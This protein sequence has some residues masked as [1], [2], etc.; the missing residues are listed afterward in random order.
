MAR[1]LLI[2]VL[3][4]L[5][6]APA[7][8]A[9][10]CSPP[11]LGHPCAIEGVGLQGGLEPE[12]SLGIGNPVH[13]AT[14]NKH[15]QET[16]LPSSPNAPLLQLVRH[17]N[18]LDTRHGAFGRGWSTSY[19][20]RLYRV[21]GRIQIVQADG[22][23]ISF[24]VNDQQ[25]L[26]NRHGLLQRDGAQWIWLW[27]DGR[28]LRF[29]QHGRLTRIS[30]PDRRPPGQDRS[31]LSID[32]IRHDQ[33]GPLHGTIE[34]IA[35]TGPAADRLELRFQYRIHGKRAYVSAVD[36]PAGRFLYR[37]EASAHAG[38]TKHEDDDTHAHNPSG[39][40]AIT[41]GS[42]AT[43]PPAPL[44]L[45]AMRRPDGLERRYL[46]EAERQSGMPQ[47]ITGIELAAPTA[48]GQLGAPTLRTHTWTYDAQARAVESQLHYPPSQAYALRITYLRPADTQHTG[49]TL[50]DG[51]GGG[52]TRFEYV[53]QAGRYALLKVDG[54]P[55]PGCA[56]PGTRAGYGKR[57]LLERINGARIRRDAAGR[58]LNLQPRAPGWPGLGFEFDSQGRRNAWHAD[59]TGKETAAFD[60]QGRVIRRRFANGD[61]W[62]YAYD[63][64]GRPA[65]ITARNRNDTQ[66]TQLR[67]AGNRLASI[68]HPQEHEQRRYDAHGR[69]MERRL[70]RPTD[71]LSISPTGTTTPT[72][73]A[74]D[75]A[76]HHQLAR[77]E[78][79]GRFE[80]T[81]RFEYDARHR[82]IV[83]HLPEGGSL[84]YDWNDQGRLMRIDWQDGQGRLQNVIRAWADLP[85]YQYGNGLT[86]VVGFQ[87]GQAHAQ[88]L[89]NDDA[90][91]WEQFR[92]YDAHNRPVRETHRF[93]A[94]NRQHHWRYTYDAHARMI[95]AR[96]ANSEPSSGALPHLTTTSS[97]LAAASSPQAAGNTANDIA[98]PAL[99]Q[100]ASN[101]PEITAAHWYAWRTDG[102]SAAA[103]RSGPSTFP[104]TRRDASGL[105]YAVDGLEL[106]YGPQRRLEQVTRRGRLLALYRHNAFGHRIRAST[107]TEDIHY[108]YLDNRLAA[109]R[110]L[111]SY[112]Q[113][114]AH[115]LPITRRYIHAGH[116][117]VGMIE[118]TDAQPHGTLYAVHTDL[119]GAP[120]FVTDANRNVRWMAR[121]SPLGLAEQVEGDLR[122]DLRLPGQMF[123]AATGWHDNL[124]RT[125]DPRFGHYLEPDPLGPVPGSQAWGYANQ[126]PRRY[127]DPLGLLLFAFDGTR[128]NAH[129]GGNVWLLSQRYL[130][131]PVFYH[132]G[133]GNPYYWDLDALAAHAA[134]QTIETQWQHL[135]NALH[136]APVS[137]NEAV[138]IDIIGYSR[139]AA[140]ARHFGN[141]VEQ[142]TDRG[143][144][145]Y[146]DPLRGQ[147]TAC[148]DLRFM[149][150]FDTVAQFGLAGALNTQYDFSIASAWGWVAHAV[151]LHERR[152]LFPLLS[153]GQ[154]TTGNLIEAPFVGA[155]ADVGGGAPP[156]TP[157]AADTHGDLSDVALNWMLWQA[158]MASVP[159]GALA[160]E[161][162]AISNPVLHDQRSSLGRTLH[163]GD[164][165]VD[166]PDGRTRHSRQDDD[167]RL[168]KT[169]REATEALIRRYDDWHGS[170]SDQ[171]GTVDLE[172]YARWLHDELGWYAPPLQAT[173]AGNH[174]II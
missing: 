164:R 113:R 10:T 140:L 62:R 13:L 154:D 73:T 54:A 161:H 171:V 144:F 147:V 34:R 155:H 25:A 142:H 31:L 116:A 157:N 100:P 146:A 130:D 89:H 153:A 76:F 136:A 4:A 131:G 68:H 166:E 139:G 23:R 80:Y 15:Q 143:L 145:S 38:H 134:P 110:L 41:M 6:F 5:N 30:V 16:D 24:A 101:D 173:P 104:D 109:E 135:L 88:A 33:S 57:G 21:G 75:T 91:I 56:P 85:G 152:S 67:W 106:A 55:C 149:G 118:Y 39:G 87:Q 2:A 51:A 158:R 48:Q 70:K 97:S 115:R 167:A 170:G 12:P 58:L 9:G 111:P 72:A 78:Y 92:Q 46:Y 32:I 50:V 14:G 84:H 129:T 64:H 43:S 169:Q 86:L 20:T 74:T 63:E 71:S 37:Y 127:T 8:A 172:A 77:S 128:M 162:T 102:A 96:E 141:L 117:L 19:D 45:T 17:Y 59:A 114:N 36:T 65:R 82:P 79:K 99:P 119:L 60:K 66:I 52:R 1:Y 90:I 125:Y 98:A 151:A 168:G 53:R 163:D 22:S 94:S 174:A 133:P 27:P 112:K 124:L 159:L 69:L 138:P 28:T 18:S 165:R 120:H 108:F 126:Q 148:V 81:D 35:T 40:A 150:L 42:A 137:A 105:P 122:F 83:H 95:A 156:G 61:E 160:A 3:L 121:Y 29:D 44:R 26:R 123:D 107:P 11:A 47:L 132:S 103:K 49:I 7:Q 93:P